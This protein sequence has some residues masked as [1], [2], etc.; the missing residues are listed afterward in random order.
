MRDNCFA[1]EISDKTIVGYADRLTDVVRILVWQSKIASSENIA[2]ALNILMKADD[3]ILR[4]ILGSALVQR[5]IGRVTSA[6]NSQLDGARSSQLETLVSDLADFINSSLGKKPSSETI[7][8]FSIEIFDP[9]CSLSTFKKGRVFIGTS[10]ELY[11][12]L[13]ISGR[14]ISPLPSS[15]AEEWKLAVATALAQI[16][17]SERSRGLV[18]NFCQHLVPI[19][20]E[21]ERVHRSLSIDAVPG[22]IF[23]ALS[24]RPYVM[25]EAIVHEADHQLLYRMKELDKETLPEACSE[26]VL[27]RSPWRDDPRPFSGLVFGLSAFSRVA[28]F[29]SD[30]L[31]LTSERQIDRKLAVRTCIAL[32]QSQ[33]AYSTIRKSV[34]PNQSAMAF[35]ASIRE[36]QDEA[37]SRLSRYREHA[38]WF[39]DARRQLSIRRAKWHHEHGLDDEIS[40]D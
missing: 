15:E 35:L 17:V 29:F 5:C 18:R 20:S 7:D 33:D 14:S 19:P 38:E 8:D 16:S 31:S 28:L 26:K 22:H 37:L 12:E 21:G 34:A 32:E 6:L 4:G 23:L 10:E 27:Y 9:L 11:S 2:L 24:H 39:D 25:A 30:L 36:E 13:M 1:V 3:T 40:V